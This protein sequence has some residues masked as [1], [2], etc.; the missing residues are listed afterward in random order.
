ME[1]RSV[2]GYLQPSREED[3]KQMTMWPLDLMLFVGGVS[4]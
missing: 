3:I 2:F 1:M 4:I